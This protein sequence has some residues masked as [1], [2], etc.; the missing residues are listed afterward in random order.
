M[1]TSGCDEVAIL[2]TMGHKDFDFTVTTYGHEEYEF[3]HQE[4]DKINFNG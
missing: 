2:K 3:L 4:M 1:L